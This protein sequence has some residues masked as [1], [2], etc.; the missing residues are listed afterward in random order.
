[1]LLSSFSEMMAMVCRPGVHAWVKTGVKN[2]GTLTARQLEARVTSGAY[3]RRS[4]FNLELLSQRF[5]SAYKCPN[6]RV[7]ACNVYTNTAPSSAF[8][9]IGNPQ[10]SWIRET[11]F[12]MIATELGI[13]PLEFRLKNIQHSG[14]E[15]AL[16]GARPMDADLPGD[17]RMLSNAIDWGNEEASGRG[18]GIAV[19]VAGPS[20]APPSSAMVRLRT[21]GKLIVICSGIEMGQGIHTAMRSI[22]S[23]ELGIPL[24]DVEVAPVVD[25]AISP[26]ERVTGGSRGTV[27]TG[28]AV[29]MATRDVKTQFIKIIAQL[30]EVPLD[31]IEI[32]DGS[33]F[34]GEHVYRVS[35]LLGQY[36]MPTAVQLWSPGV[37]SS[38]SGVTRSTHKGGVGE[39]LG[40]GV[41]APGFDNG[42]LDL[43]PAFWETAMGA[44]EVEVD[45]ETGLFKLIRYIDLAEAGK[46]LDAQTARGQGEGA[47]MQGLGH[48]IREQMLYDSQGQLVNGSPLD[49]RVV[50][51]Q[52]V[53]DQLESIIIENADGPGA[54]GTKGLGEGSIA[55]IAP[56]IT[57]AIGRL[58]GVYMHELPITPQRLW[59]ALQ[60]HNQ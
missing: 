42:R 46:V 34:V 6:V 11:Q 39:I 35:E 55:P 25:T 13:D 15:G 1:K 8:R 56:A 10:G 45:H 53:P 37:V 48:T 52:D 38:T 29:Q 57:S 20:A 9:S 58:T 43:K 24:E 60:R 22:A 50:M 30:L 12:D 3:A 16:V 19:A 47:A 23:L 14:E 36:F 5:L 54:F 28:L 21:N 18:K 41:I 4:P 59:E 26:F 40:Q 44:A 31:S 33:V 49:Y 51:M 7:D 17:L 2:D 32:C 27:V